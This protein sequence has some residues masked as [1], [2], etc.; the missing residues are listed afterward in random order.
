M[1]IPTSINRR[2]YQ[3][4]CVMKTLR[5]TGLLFSM[6]IAS[7]VFAITTTVK[8]QPGASVSFQLFYDELAPYGEWINDAEY[9]YMWLPNAGSDFQP[10][11]TNGHWVMTNYGNTWVSNYDW[12]WAPFHY[13]R[14]AYTDYYGWAWVPGYEWGPAWVSWRS[15]GGYYGWAPLGPRMSISVNIGIPH[16]HW[17][18]VPQRYITSP[19]IYSYYAP[20]RNR[21]TIYNRTTIINNTYVYN[22]N[23][24]VSGPG[25]SELERVTRSRISVRNVNAANRPGRAQ[26]DSRSVNLYR[27]AVDRNTRTSARPARVANATAV[28]ATGNSRS[29]VAPANS[30]SS[31]QR[32]NSDAV[33]TPRTSTSRNSSATATRQT[34]SGSTRASSARSSTNTRATAPSSRTNT[35]VNQ[36]APSARTQSSSAVTQSRAN[37]TSTPA[38]S[39]NTVRASSAT[40]AGSSRTSSATSSGNSRATTVRSTTPAQSRPAVSSS[41]STSSRSA[42]SSSNSRTSNRSNNTSSSRSSR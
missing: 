29:A 18:F 34:N 36:T 15:G 9:G 13:G 31:A 37:R 10:Y 7:L 16:H 26:V 40:N 27:P 41:R 33:A 3:N 23:T 12:G 19:R 42:V 5:K 6:A 1:V 39:R 2:M 32:A 30:R 24:Y 35:R 38:S 14:W 11:A 4:R 21:V 17:V 8:A 25:R 20:Y 22:N 28:R